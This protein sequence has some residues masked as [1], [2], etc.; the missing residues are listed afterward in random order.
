MNEL[1]KKFDLIAD[2]PG[3]VPK[4]RQL[5]LDLAVRGKL[6]PQDPS[7]EPASELLKKIEAE[8]RRL[9]QAGEIKS[10][11]V[12][13]KITE[14]EKSYQLPASW[15]WMKLRDVAHDWGQ[16]TPGSRF[17]YIDVGSIENKR[18]VISAEVQ[19]LE[20][21]EAPS[22]ARKVVKHGTVIYSTVRPYLLNI[23]IIDKDYE[24]EPI[25]ST[26]FAILHPY[27]MISNQYL[28]FYLRSSTLI[29]Y[30]EDCMK[31]VAYPAINDAD[32]F[33]GPFPLP[34]LAEQKRIVAKVD[35]LM[36]ICDQLEAQQAERA[37]RHAVLNRAAL[38]RFRDEPTP[39]NLRLLFHPDFPLSPS[40]LR[41]TILDLAVR[42]KLVAFA[43]C[44]GQKVGDHIEFLNGYAFKSEWFKS[45]GVRLCRN[46]NIGH[47]DINWRQS[48]FV[49]PD[50]E[51][52]FLRF[53]LNEGDIVLSLDR[54]LIST[55]LKVATVKS[56]DLPC[57]LLQ[58]VAKPMPKHS[59]IHMP[60]FMLWL[61][62]SQFM[63]TIDPGRSNGIP[64]ISTRQVE[65]LPFTLPPLAE[66]KR[67]VAR[68]NELMALVDELEGQLI[69]TR[70][71]AERLSQLIMTPTHEGCP[72]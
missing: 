52:Q 22:R 56:S 30:V 15:E 31:G 4:L 35:E 51:Q 71:Q 43:F 2:I 67:I 63:D 42:G 11:K 62:S 46:I 34:P 61:N 72:P 17:T 64:H 33:Q 68:V 21:S 20:A 16:K 47:G 66:Q 36:A 7:D 41:K 48:A 6:V 8:K 3:A 70:A 32:F 37:E 19:S 13:T 24:F 53:A 65:A 18:G 54:P 58:R 49:D 59:E 1:L 69:A 9:V 38:T 29:G 50:I 12:A 60:Y 23:A 28:Y 25:A 39:E 26:A 55:G 27:Q 10:Q 44:G 57:L 40:D 5:I 45:A 14:D